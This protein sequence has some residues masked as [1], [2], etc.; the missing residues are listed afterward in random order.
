MKFV[1][2][3]QLSLFFPAYNEEENIESTIT[4]AAKVLPKVASKYEIVVVDDGSR[5]K[6]AAKVK[7]LQKKYKFLR[8]EQ[9]QPN[10]GY[11]GA[12]KTGFKSTKY[13]PVVFTDSDGQ[14]DFGEVTKLISAMQSSQ[15]DLVIGYRIKRSDPPKRLWIAN[16]LKLWNLFW[17]GMWFRDT[18]CGFK[19][20]RRRVLDEVMPLKSDG[21]IISTEFLAKVKRSGF[22][23]VQVGVHHY[24]RQAGQST[25]DN[26]KVIT[27]AVKETLA[28]WY[29]INFA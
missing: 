3:D 24:P 28:I 27:K 4:A 11:G 20:I 2:L 17:F 7:A 14:F 6:T 23:Y 26:L 13:D 9:H 1:K 10:R 22:G 16:M 19:L 8:L 21:G 15:A 29:D 5:D 12:L 18:D 25:G